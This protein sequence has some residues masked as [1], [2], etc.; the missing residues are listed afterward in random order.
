M[1]L[2]VIT[3]SYPR[4]PGDH[5]GNFVAAHVDALRVMGHDVEVIAAGGESGPGITR[6]PSPLFERG[7][8]PDALERHPGRALA[9]GAWFAARLTAMVARRAHR[10]DSIIAHWLA[11][12]AL[13]ALPTRAPLL[14]IA[15]GGDVHTLRR[16]RLLGPAL[17]LLHARDA[18]LVFVSAELRGLAIAAAPRLA[19]WL[20]AAR[21]Q[22]MGISLARFTELAPARTDPPTLLIVSRLVPIKGIDIAIEAMRFV[23][24]PVRLVIAGDGPERTQLEHHARQGRDLGARIE[25]VGAVDTS[26]RDRLL[27]AASVVLVPSRVT[28][29]GRT[30]G[31][32]MIALE[33]LAA[34]VPVIASAVGG[35]RDLSAVHHVAPDD[36]RSLA[37]AIDRVLAAPPDASV[38]RAAVGGLDWCAVAPHLVSSP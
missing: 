28:P 11:P 35:L 12:S 27:G 21:I 20:E 17:H 29:S 36:P 18:K 6:I 26:D 25:L 9:E 4:S 32:P 8:A 24:T 22:P 3:T 38:L 10:W 31:T 15:H 19:A 34:G 33:A 23:Q 1:K 37:V 7:G 30:E 14:A 5:A 2:G 13:A 16:L